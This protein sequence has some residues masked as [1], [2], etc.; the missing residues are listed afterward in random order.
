MTAIKIARIRKLSD[1]ARFPRTFEARLA[2]LDPGLIAALTA[3]QL[4]AIIDGPMARSY[5]AG[6]N[7]GLRDA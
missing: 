3:A 6:H 5:S 1:T 7:A 4:A 2:A